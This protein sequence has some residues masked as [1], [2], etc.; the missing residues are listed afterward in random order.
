MTPTSPITPAADQLYA[1]LAVIADP[2]TH[3]QRL[4]E[5]VAQ[6][7]AT[8]ERIDALNEMAADTRRLNS[9]AQAA[10]IVSDNRKTALDARETEL[11]ERAKSLDI[12]AAAQKA[13]AQATEQKLRQREAD[14]SRRETTVQQR[15]DRI[16]ETE[17]ATK[18][19]LAVA[20]SLKEKL[21]RQAAA[22]KVAMAQ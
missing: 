9:A 5:L 20:E 19:A 13:A 11:G 18:S 8:Q 17:V 7:K 16:A 2:A 12:A 4:D 21:Q 10:N 14:V 6:E 3:K 1:L 15:E 22:V